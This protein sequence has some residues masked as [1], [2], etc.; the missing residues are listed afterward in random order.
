MMRQLVAGVAGGPLRTTATMMG[1]CVADQDLAYDGNVR[2]LM[3]LRQWDG[4]PPKHR[5][6][7]RR[8]LEDDSSG[9]DEDDSSGDDDAMSGPRH[10]D[11]A[12]GAAAQ[13]SATRADF[14]VPVA[15]H[16]CGCQVGRASCGAR[17]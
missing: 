13:Y 11:A 7:P 6:P 16:E 14:S 9:D 3:N 17:G 10:S 2:Y 4:F 1:R 5:P 8:L 12:A 15:V